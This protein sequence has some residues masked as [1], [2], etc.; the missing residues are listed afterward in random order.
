[1]LNKEEFIVKCC[2][3]NNMSIEE[4]NKFWDVFPCNCEY[5]KCEGWKVELKPGAL[6]NLVKNKMNL[7]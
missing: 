2:K 6:Y 5:K 4:F 7:N 3:N 1:M